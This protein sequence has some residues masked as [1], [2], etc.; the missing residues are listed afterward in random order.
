[1]PNNTPLAPLD[2]APRLDRLR[3]EM[4]GA[5]LSA[6]MVTGRSNVRYLTGFSGSAGLLLVFEDHA[7]LVT[8]GRYMTQA[9]EQLRASA[10]PATA[11]IAPGP[12]QGK[13]VGDLVAKAGRS[14]AKAGLEAD[15]ISW[16]LQRQVATDWLPGIEL[17]PTVGLVESLR[18]VKDPGEVDRIAAA[19][20]IADDALAA[21]RPLLDEGC[22]EVDFAL[23][24]DSEMR[25]RGAQGPSF[26]TIC[27]SGPNAAKPH[28]RPSSRRVEP[29]EPVVVDFGAIVEGYCSD[30]TRTVWVGELRDPDLRRALQ[31]VAASQAAGVR[32]V[33][34]GAACKEV[35]RACREV[36]GDAGWA[37]QFIHGTGHGVG[38]D[39]HEAPAV[40]A[41]SPD[42]LAPGHV[43]T[44][45]PGVYLPGLGG[46]RIEDTLV[47]TDRGS[48]TLTS[49]PKEVCA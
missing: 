3:H 35:D 31:V 16:A 39:I 32:A 2:V 34:A 12:A 43:V 36:I 15:H 49:T 25:R 48:R 20:M 11:E 40:S 24:L 13:L 42:T 26:E 30:M 9:E 19:A 10:A 27:A 21:V 22:S 38:L 17:V 33:A 8:D 47:V 29:G 46:V 37:E 6:L 18:R 44:V 1:V 23:T 45:E 14:A 5:Q 7:V 28:H 4:A 41:T